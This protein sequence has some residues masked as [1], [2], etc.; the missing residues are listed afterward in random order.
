MA[1]K[2][3]EKKTVS[4]KTIVKKEPKK[5]LICEGLY[6]MAP[7]VGNA[8]TFCEIKKD[9]RKTNYDVKVFFK[10]GLE[11]TEEWTIEEAQEML[12]NKEINK[13]SSIEW[14]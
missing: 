9:G 12:D 3:A 2:V 6:A 13:T 1:N 14:T 11:H 10:S 4:K 8:P 7:R 5:K